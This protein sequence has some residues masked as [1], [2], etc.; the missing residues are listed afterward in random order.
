MYNREQRELTKAFRH[1]FNSP[2]GKV[3][4]QFLIEEYGHAAINDENPIKMAT[5]VGARNLV[6]DILTILERED[7]DG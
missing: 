2:D 3:V 5:G 6:M 1:V 4:L 7:D